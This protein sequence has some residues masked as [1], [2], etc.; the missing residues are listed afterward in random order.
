MEARWY[1][2]RVGSK[3][4]G[5]EGLVAASATMDAMRVLLTTHEACLEHENAPGHPERPERIQAAVDGVLRSGVEVIEREAPRAAVEAL[6]TSHDPSYVADIRR[7]CEA[8]GRALDLDTGVVAGSW[9]AALRSAGAG[10][11]A[12]EVLRSGDADAA[13]LATRPPGHHALHAKA[14]GFCL[15]NNI[16]IA[17]ELVTAAGETVAI[18]DFDVHHGNGTQEAFYGREDVVYVSLHQFPFYPGTGW[19][20]EIGRGSGEGHTVNVPLAAGSG[21]D[22]VRH[23]V[24]GIAAPVFDEFD[25]D[26]MFVS[27]GFDAHLRDPLAELQYL[28]QDYGWMA[29]RLLAPRRGRVVFFLEGGYDLEAITSSVDATIRGTGGETYSP[30]FGPSPPGS[31]RLIEMAAEQAA[32]HWSGVQ[33]S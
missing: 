25:P 28:D 21:G 17:T 30:S 7:A 8:G 32:R 1:G 6:H 5:A 18:F 13:F 29:N 9:E 20:E 10:I 15:F 4:V 22:A 14:M 31:D 12:I 27:A 19:V 11:D 26:W 3:S 2:A 24:D 16:A 33:A 23:A